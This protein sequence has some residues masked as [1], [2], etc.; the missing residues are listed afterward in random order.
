MGFDGSP[1]RECQGSTA[2]E[3]QVLVL[4]IRPC[5][6]FMTSLPE[7]RA[8]LIAQAAR[9]SLSLLGPACAMPSC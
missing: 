7:T 4:A 8:K 6:A 3:L 2:T 1:E 9:D 5:P